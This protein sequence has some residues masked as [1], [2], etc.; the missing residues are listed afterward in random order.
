MM[1]SVL[2]AAVIGAGL[3]WAWEQFSPAF[4]TTAPMTPCGAG[5][6]TTTDGLLPGAIVG[7]GVQIILR[8]TE[9]S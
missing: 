3:L 5:A 1:K 8:L 9:V 6:A 4:M 2:I 7:A